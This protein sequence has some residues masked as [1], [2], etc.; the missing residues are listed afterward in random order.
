MSE[1]NE[2]VTLYDGSECPEED[3]VLIE[4]GDY[5]GHYFH[6]DE[7]VLT[8]LDGWVH[9]DQVVTSVCG[10]SMYEG[11][12]SN[13][14]Y[15]YDIDGDIIHLDE[16]IYLEDTGEYVH[17]DSGREYYYHDNDGYY[18]YPESKETDG[19]YDYHDGPRNDLTTSKTKFVF[20]VEVEKCDREDLVCEYEL[21]EVDQTHWTRE[22]DASVD[23]GFELI[24]PKYDLFDDRFDNDIL[25]DS[26][27]GDTLRDHINGPYDHSCGGHMSFSIVG[28]SGEEAFSKYSSFFPVLISL[29][30]RRL[31]KSYA[32]IRSNTS[33]KRGHVKYS[34][35]LVHNRYVEFRIFSA[36]PNVWTLLW[37][38]DL[39]R[40]MARSPKKGFMWWIREALTEG[41][42][43]NTH[44][45][46]Q[47]SQEQIEQRMIYAVAIA[48]HMMEKKYSEYVTFA[49]EPQIQSAKRVIASLNSY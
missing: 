30:Y 33:L 26:R 12:V 44:L 1:E 40:I 22:L 25:A 17:T 18:S 15:V 11:Y 37:R 13:H 42:P 46:I 8:D 27:E 24:S 16:A 48:E 7:C 41:R 49:T 19:C 32:K 20:G 4:C 5:D 36:V 39:L 6:K 2:M 10:T 28:K 9:Q 31:R 29:Y 47:Y 14:D 45:R 21:C 23:E 34:A 35:I 43:L 38:R 3:S